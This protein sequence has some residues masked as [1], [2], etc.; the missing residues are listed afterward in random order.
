MND[1]E[2]LVSDVSDEA[3]E[4][5]FPTYV[6]LESFMR[7]LLPVTEQCL[8]LVDKAEAYKDNYMAFDR[9]IDSFVIL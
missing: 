4:E 2:T 9:G 3:R 6:F 5:D 7:D 8:L 1:L